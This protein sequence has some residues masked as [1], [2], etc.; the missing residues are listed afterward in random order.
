MSRILST[1]DISWFLDLYDKGQLNLNPSYQRRSVWSPKD[2]RYFIDTIL[3]NYP[4]PPI[5]LHKTL[6]DQGRSTYHVVDGKQRLQSIIH[7]RD[8]KISIPDDFS[9]ADLRNKKWKDLDKLTKGDFWNYILIVEMMPDN[10]ES[11]I[12]STFERINR[13]SRK[14]TQQ[15][16]RH[17]KYEGWFI[18]KVESEAELDEW[19]QIG[20]VTNARAKRMADAQFISELMRIVIKNSIS[21]FDQDEIDELYA[22]YDDISDNGDFVEDDFLERFR[23]YKSKV[24]EMITVKP[25]IR[26]YTKA[27]GHLYTL[28]SAIN[29]LSD[30]AIVIERFANNYYKFIR[31]TSLFIDGKIEDISDNPSIYQI[32]IRDYASN[33]RG[34]STDLTQR[35][36]RLTA[37]LNAINALNE[38]R[39]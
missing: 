24:L 12:K 14:L 9:N 30:D 36:K 39:V 25:E 6:D 2:R 17:A 23:S 5:F 11:T 32:A 26:E 18:S 19:R 7:F 33:I 29:A 16:M 37:L 38:E 35:E 3:N 8:N 20:V 15:E 13:N 27:N 10:Q 31:D 4:A 21:G 34:A 1:Q 22:E 28:W